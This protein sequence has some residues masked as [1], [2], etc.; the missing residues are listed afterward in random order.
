[1]TARLLSLAKPGVSTLNAASFERLER[2]QAPIE[3]PNKTLPH[4]ERYTRAIDYQTMLL[5][6]YPSV[7]CFR[8][9]TLYRVGVVLNPS[10]YPQTEASSRGATRL[11]ADTED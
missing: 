10:L 6:C 4:S 3:L 7:S 2:Q 8:L 11:G 5:E 9:T 1:M